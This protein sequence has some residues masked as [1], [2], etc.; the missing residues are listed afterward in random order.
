M[1]VKAGDLIG[2]VGDQRY[3]PDHLHLGVHSPKG[4]ADAKARIRAVANAPRVS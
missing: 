4:A 3:R 1:K 2:Y